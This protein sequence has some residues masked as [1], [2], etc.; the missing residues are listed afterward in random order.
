LDNFDNQKQEN[1]GWATLSMAYVDNDNNIT[2]GA[3]ATNHT[4]WSWTESIPEANHAWASAGYANG[5]SENIYCANKNKN[6]EGYIY[7]SLPTGIKAGSTVRLFY[8]WLKDYKTV[9]PT[10]QDIFVTLVKPSGATVDIDSQLGAP[11][12]Y[13]TWYVVD[14]DIS[15]FFTESGTYKIRM[16]YDFQTPNMT[17]AEANAKFDEVRIMVNNYQLDV[18]ENV[19][20]IVADY[21]YKVQLN[22]R[23][24]NNKEN[25]RVQVQNASNGW[26]NF[27]NVITYRG[28]NWTTWENNVNSSYIVSNTVR[29]RFVGN[30][31]KYPLT[32]NLQLDYVRVKK[33]NWNTVLS[34]N[35]NGNGVN[36]PIGTPVWNETTTLQTLKNGIEGG[37]N[38]IRAHMYS[39]LDPKNKLGTYFSLWTDEITLFDGPPFDVSIVL[40]SNPIIAPENLDSIVENLAFFSNYNSAYYTLQIQNSHGDWENFNPVKQDNVGLNKV[41][42]VETIGG[43]HATTQYNDPRNYIYNDVINMMITG[44]NDN[45]PFSLCLDYLDFQVNYKENSEN[46]LASFYGGSGKLTFTMINYSYPNQTYIYDDGAVIVAQSNSSAMASGGAPTPDLMVV[47]DM[48]SNNIRVDVNHFALTGSGRSISRGGWS[49]IRATVVDSYYLNQGANVPNVSID[50]YTSPSTDQAWVNYLSGLFDDF[51]ARG[52]NSTFSKDILA[53]TDGEH[54]TLTIYGNISYYEKVTQIQ[55]QLA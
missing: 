22:F 13:N 35:V 6:G 17:G 28:G 38:K 32:T 18:F 53:D 45:L 39:Y 34:Y 31:G 7:Q 1:G 40:T 4:G 20:S 52:Y 42:W 19:G 11:A 37:I 9:Y 25:F 33:H 43:V 16:R 47:T 36:E 41:Y 14:K 2:N 44:H 49:A 3:F 15:S 23:L 48:G 8:A 54:L 50:I 27:D 24:D 10:Q 5:G 46:Y 21:S 30:S 12:A 51:I 55:V 26:D 29:L